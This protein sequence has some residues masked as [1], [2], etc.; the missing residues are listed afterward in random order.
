MEVRSLGSPFEEPEQVALRA[1]L[2]GF[3]DVASHFGP[4]KDREEGKGGR[5]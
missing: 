4:V 1:H 3:E 5:G 2:A